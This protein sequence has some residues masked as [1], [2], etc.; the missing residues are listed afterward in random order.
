RANLL[1]GFSALENLQLAMG[2]AAVIPP[3][4]RRQRASELLEQV[5]L[6]DRLHHRP[7]QLSSG[8]QQRV[9]LARALVNRPAL[10]LADEPTASVDYETGR[11]IVVLL[12]DFCARQGAALALVSHDRELLA[13]FGTIMAL[14]AGRLETEA[15]AGASPAATIA[16]TQGLAPQL[17]MSSPNTR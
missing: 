9:A 5:G 1:D 7:A 6:A 10:V 14:R 8:Q 2:F 11:K 3:N 17:P 13:S 16:H 12:R 15:H 4:Q